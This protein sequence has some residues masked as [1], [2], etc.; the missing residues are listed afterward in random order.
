[1]AAVGEEHVETIADN[2]TTEATAPEYSPKKG[3]NYQTMMTTCGFTIC[4]QVLNVT[5]SVKYRTHDIIDQYQQLRTFGNARSQFESSGRRHVRQ[6]LGIP[7]VGDDVFRKR[8]P[9]SW[10][11]E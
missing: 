5:F 8:V 3:E 10:R 6:G 2:E 1:M 11:H 9:T 4:Y 7:Q